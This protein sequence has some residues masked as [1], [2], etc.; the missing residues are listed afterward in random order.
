VT[1][2]TAVAPAAE[3]LSSRLAFALELVRE[4]SVLIRGYYQTADLAVERKRDLSPVT[5]ADK[6]TELLIR[7]RLATAFPYDAILGEEFPDKEGP[8]GFRWILDPIDGTKS[9]V[10][11]VP[12]FGT[13]IGVEYGSQCVVGVVQFPALNEVVY[14]ARGSG[15]WWQIGDNE[16]RPAR[17]S[18]VMNLAEAT[19][20]TTNPS[21]WFKSGHREALETLLSS[22]QLARGWGDCFGHMLVATG[23]ADVMIDP[24]MNAWDAAALQPII[25]E[26][27]GHFIDW[28]GEP[29]I[30]GGSGISV[31]PGLKAAVLSI[32]KKHYEIDGENFSTLDEFYDEISRVLVPGVEWGRNLNALNDILRGGF[33]T[34]ESGF[35]LRWKNSTLSRTRL[36]YAETVRQ[37]EQQIERCHPSNKAFIEHD[38]NLAHAGRGSTVFDWL[39]EIFQVHGAGGT[40][41]DDGV[42]LVLD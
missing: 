11:G 15:A 21:R 16:P 28:S 41:A 18:S 31:V 26:A 29:T 13:L 9:F 40:E 14:A 42:E 22:V 4:T 17:V 23:R 7:E 36:G 12:L 8:S 1:T 5:E 10:H 32:L 19:F 30:Y 6:N 38:L 35:L 3:E 34:P 24:A 27:G 39:I 25:E 2:P 20:C 37:L 33:G